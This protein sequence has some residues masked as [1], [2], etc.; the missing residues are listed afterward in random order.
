MQATTL[1]VKIGQQPVQL[2]YDGEGLRIEGDTTAV[3]RPKSSRT[4][5]CIP[6]PGG[7]SSDPLLLPIQNLNILNVELH[8][9]NMLRISALIPEN[10]AEDE[11]SV[12]L[13]NLAYSVD[14]ENAKE[15][16]E[17]SSAIMNE[18][19]KDVAPGKR[20]KVLINPFGGQG[21]AKTI[22]ERQVKPVFEAAK[23]VMDV[24][25]TERHGHAIDIAKEINIDKFDSIVTV[26]GDGVIHEV[27]NGFLQ[28]SDAREAIRKLPLGVIPGGT[29]NALS[30]SLLGE[31]AGFDPQ[32]TALQVIKGKPMTFDLCSVTYDDHRYFSFLSQNYGITAYADLGTEHMR[33]MGDGRTIVGLLQQIFGKRTYSMEASF[34]VIESDKF[35]IAADY[36][37]AYNCSE[38]PKV[39]NENEPTGAVIDSIPPLSE[40]VPETWTTVNGDISVFLTSKVPWLARGMLS[41]PYCMPNDGLL[42]LMLIKEGASVGKQLDVFTKVEKGNHVSNDIVDYYK[43][44]AFRLTPISKSSEKKNY[45]AI[46]GEHAPAKPFQVEVHPCLGAVLSLEGRYR[47]T[48]N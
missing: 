3:K 24:Q 32:Y 15:A 27:I 2:T 9:T 28:R 17:F 47:P 37:T 35:K 19:Y 16:K 46:D 22:Y 44:K 26:S 6:L 42:D 5:F 48:T 10:P 41:H 8:D 20:I 21:K 43:V 38:E 30:I 31:K 4:C 34:D 39:I 40:P 7:K 33:W 12:K 25:F 36:Q 23:C 11:S 29:G 1:K 13:Y 14:S 18:V 45:V